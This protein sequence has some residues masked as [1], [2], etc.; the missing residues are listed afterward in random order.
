MQM[1]NKGAVAGPRYTE[2]CPNCQENWPKEAGNLTDAYRVQ[3]IY[4]EYWTGMSPLGVKPTPPP[5]DRG[6]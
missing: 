6:W 1:A 5:R 3:Y 2:Y 4:Q